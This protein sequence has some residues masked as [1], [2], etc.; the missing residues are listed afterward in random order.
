MHSTHIAFQAQSKQIK[1]AQEKMIFY[2][3]EIE[4]AGKKQVLLLPNSKNI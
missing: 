4:T 1:K 3:T 2:M